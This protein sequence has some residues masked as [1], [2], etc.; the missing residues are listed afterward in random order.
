MII[1]RCDR[2]GET[3][4]DEI[5]PLWKEEFVILDKKDDFD[6]LYGW[7]EYAVTREDIEA[8]RNGKRLYSDMGGEY[9]ITIVMKGAD[10][11]ETVHNEQV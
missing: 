7:T 4:D 11:A 6:H 3:G 9:A 1:H 10:D 2:C 5:T 8:L